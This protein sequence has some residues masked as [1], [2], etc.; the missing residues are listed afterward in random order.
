M[1]KFGTT[2]V[3]QTTLFLVGFGAAQPLY[4]GGWVTLHVCN[5]GTAHVLVVTAMKN[6]G[7]GM[8]Y[9]AIRS[10]VVA[11]GDC[12]TVYSDMYGYPAYF[13]FG[14]EDANG[15]WGSG[16]VAQVPDMGK[17]VA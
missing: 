17:Y 9:W 14:F 12:E 8:H 1:K 4:A 13:G 10:T 7:F 5:K 15:Q 6:T 11:A 16:K 3:L 2:L